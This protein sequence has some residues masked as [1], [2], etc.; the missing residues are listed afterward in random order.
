M[1]RILQC[2]RSIGVGLSVLIA[3]VAVLLL[4]VSPTPVSAQEQEEA[5]AS[6][7][8]MVPEN[9]EDLA[10]VEERVAKVVQRCRPAT[11]CVQ[12][13]G[14]SG[15]GVIISE[16][17]Y[18]LTAGH[19]AVEPGRPVTFIFPDGKK[20]RGKSLGINVGI[21][22]GLMKITDKGKWPH[23][24]L[25]EMTNV[26]PGAWVVAMGHPGGFDKER[27][28]V[29]RL[30]RVYRVRSSVIQTDCTIIGGDSGGPLFDLDGKVIGIHSRISNSLRQN[31]HVPIS[32]Y[33]DNWDKLAAGEVWNR[34]PTRNNLRPGG[35]YI[36][37]QGQNGREQGNGAA[38]SRVYDDSPAAEAG[39]RGGDV[40]VE[41]DRS[42]IASF[43]DL[44]EVVGNLEPGDRVPVVVMRRGERVELQ[45]VIG[46]AG[47]QE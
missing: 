8:T 1:N 5:D 12:S 23:V 44:A 34:L 3:V 4:S 9:A 22:A 11:V 42:P 15:S 25:G 32:I 2:C 16:D 27:S 14:G 24:E 17:G 20:A 39:M 46:K 43:G 40:V 7:A 41:L 47:E 26:K 37:V 45:V 19:V 35:P 18:V 31:F 28:V 38:L 33:N 29:A 6:V 30:G 36:G 13:G 10:Q 21:D